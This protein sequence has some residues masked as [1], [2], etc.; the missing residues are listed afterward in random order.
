VDVIPAVVG[1][2]QTELFQTAVAV[3]GFRINGEVDV[4]PAVVGL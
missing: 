2:L 3:S 1:L 4:I